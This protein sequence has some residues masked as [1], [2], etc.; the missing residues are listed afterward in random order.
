MRQLA[1]QAVGRVSE[2]AHFVLLSDQG[3]SP[4]EIAQ[5]M[6]YNTATV[7]TWLQAYAQRGIAG[8]K[9]APR[10]GRPPKDKLLTGVVQAQASQPPPNFG[11]LPA[12]WTVALLMRHLADRF[13]ITV[14]FSTL[15]RALHR[16]GLRWKR[17]KLAPARRYDPLAAEKQAR[18]EQVLAD[19]E[20]TLIAEDECEVHLLPMLRAMWQRRGEQRRLVT[21]GQ[22][23]KRS[24]FGALNL[25]TGEWLYQVTDRKRG[26]EFIALLT[27]YPTGM[28]Y[29]IVDNASI[30]TCRAVQKWLAEHPRLQLVYLPTYSGHQLNPVEKV[31]WDLKDNIAANRCFKDLVELEAAIRRYFAS[32]SPERASRLTTSVVVRKAQNKA[33]EK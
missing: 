24:I 10:N 3:H 17:P 8:L 20:A 30:H 14:S 6:G 16:A 11:Y 1:R 2:R 4:P 28:I 29:V 21:P 18:L 33:A 27:A 23:G 9:D 32:F 5:L 12:Y 26:V 15:R 31:W 22:N 19:T 7:R 25:R 13:G